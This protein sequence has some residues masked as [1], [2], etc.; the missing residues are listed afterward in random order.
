MTGLFRLCRVLSAD[1]LA[2]SCTW[3]RI[4]P[5]YVNKL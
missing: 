1:A 2:D 4:L 5:E 3:V